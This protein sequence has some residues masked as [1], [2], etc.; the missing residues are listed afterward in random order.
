[1]EPTSKEKSP[2]LIV[3][4]NRLPVSLG[5]DGWETSP[6]GLVAALTSVLE[7]RGGTWVGGS[8]TPDSEVEPF[9]HDGIDLVPFSV[10]EEEQREY[11]DGFSN[12]TLWPLYHHWVRPPVL[13]EPT[14]WTSY[15]QVNDRVAERIAAVAEVGS[16]VWVHD[17]QLQLVPQRVRQLR[18]DLRIG[19][20]LHI[21]FPPVELFQRLPW[22]TQ[23][24]EGILGADVAG[25]QT[26]SDVENFRAAVQLM[27]ERADALD[28]EILAEP[29]LID[30]QVRADPIS[31]DVEQCRELADDVGVQAYAAT[32]RD[33]VGNP[34]YLLL[35]VDRLD[36]TK[37]ILERLSAFD[38]LLRRH[39]GLSER[40]QLLQVAVPSRE[41]VEEYERL[42]D[43]VEQLVGRINGEHGEL[44]RT[45]VHYHF[46]ELSFD[47]IVA[48]YLAADVLLVTP[49][50]D[51]MNLV[52]KEYVIARDGDPVS[53]VISE[54]AGAAEELA[55]GA[56]VV[57]VFDPESI[58]MGIERAITRDA[59]EARRRSGEMAAV[60]ADRDVHVWAADFLGAL[61][62][63]D[64]SQRPHSTP[65]PA[66]LGHTVD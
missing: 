49:L 23:I 63:I 51:G 60:V 15:E 57:N 61:E 65:P 32:I 56:D 66:V 46:A 24:L 58:I 2:K 20:Y 11:Y 10:T 50:A 21:P 42:R 41:S 16:T 14:W 9:R 34:D 52:A 53:V 5:P 62:S 33:R 13:D 6:G 8:G 59:D 28:A 45:V 26:A 48:L 29:G 22:R 64:L 12:A 35:G 37:G 36:Y 19:F 38:L 54:F 30:T 27:D 1:M 39:P 55:V 17:Y 47:R 31:I 3:A 18:S 44:G 4:S 43:E 7:A 25:F 40:V